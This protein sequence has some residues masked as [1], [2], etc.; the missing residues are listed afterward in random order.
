MATASKPN[1]IFIMGDQHSRAVTG[2]YGHDI[3]QTPNIDR[4]A[5]TGIRYDNAFCASPLC[6]PSRVSWITGTQPHTHGAVTHNNNRH[7]SGKAYKKFIEP[8]IH[9]LVADLRDAGY[10]TH[11]A[12]FMHADQHVEGADLSSHGLGFVRGNQRVEGPDPFAELGFTS[13]NCDARS[14]TEQVGEQVQQRYNRANIIS[15]MWEHSYRNVEGDPFPYPEEQMWDS[16]ITDDCL[17]FLDHRDSEQPFFAYVGYRAPHSPW[18]APERFHSMYDPDHIGDLPN[19]KVQ[20]T[21]KPRRVIER[22]NYYELWNVPEEMIRKS[23]AAYYGFVTYFDHCIGRIIDGLEARGLREDTLI[24]YASDHGEMLYN[25]GICEKHTFFEDA[26]RIPLVFS[27]PG[28]LPEGTTSDAMV[29]NIDLMPT[30]LHLLDI[31][32]PDFV[33]G[34]DLADTFTGG[35]VQQHIFSEYYHSLDPCR[36]VRDKRYKY[37]HTE[38]DVCELYD[39]E[40][41]PLESINLAWYPQYAERIAQMEKLVMAGWEIPEVPVWAAWNDLNERKQKMRLSGADI[42]DPRP[43]PPDWIANYS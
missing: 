40:N 31:P 26:V 43:A 21:D 3:V 29:S 4:L 33:E 22:I 41:D 35:E 6:G 38:E 10:E 27:Q 18:C 28:Q 2:C 19:Y 24:V 39:L 12:G 5:D 15:E 23:I 42:I 20:Y 16:L 34:K 37:I 1:I 25:N 8:G 11:G 14:Y 13:Y 9:S 32:V 36:M 30:L 17:D 7:R